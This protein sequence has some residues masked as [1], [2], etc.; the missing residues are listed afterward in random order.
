[1][2]RRLGLASLLL[3]AGLLFQTAGASQPADRGGATLFSG[4]QL[5]ADAGQPPI[6][7]SAFVVEGERI[8]SVGRRNDVRA[9]A[10]AARVDLTGKTVMPAIVNAHG[11]VG[12]QKDATFDKA[13]YTRENI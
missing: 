4:A 3:L 12:F 5:I 7:D 1:M 10:G 8:V 13:N 6:E 11:H 2:A 9:P